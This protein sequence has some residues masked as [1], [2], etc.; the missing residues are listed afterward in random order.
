MDDL[1]KDIVKRGLVSF[2][3]RGKA[4]AVFNFIKVL[5]TTEPIETD[6]E[7]WELYLLLNNRQ[8]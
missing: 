1:L 3:S 8:N 7:W 4:Q 2:V 6:R 5:A